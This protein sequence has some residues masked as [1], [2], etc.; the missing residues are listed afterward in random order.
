MEYYSAMKKKAIVPFVTMGT[1]LEG[2]IMLNEISQIQKDK[3]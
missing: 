3:S 2:I 1:D